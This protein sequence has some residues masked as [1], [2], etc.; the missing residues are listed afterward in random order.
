M[1]L[2]IFAGG[3]GRRLWPISRQKSPKQ[4]EPILGDKSTL[5]LAVDRVLA[6]YGGENIFISTNEKYVEMVRAQLPQ[7][8]AENVIGEPAR[9]DLA[10][11][12]GLALTHLAYRAKDPEEPVAILWGDNYMDQVP[13]F[14]GVLAAAEELLHTEQARIL[15]VGETPRFA[16]DNLGW[17]GLGE[18][19]GEV[20]GR[21]YYRFA[22]LTYRPPLA[23]C[24]RMFAEKTH[25]W[26]TGYFV[27]T[28]GFVR[29]QYEQRQPEI[30]QQL[31]EIGQTIG[32]ADYLATLHRVYPQI[33]SMSFDDAILQHIAPQ[34]AAVLHGH[35]GWSDP[36]TLYAL[37]EAINPNLAANVT[38]GQV[39]VHQSSDCLIY[40]YETD[41]LV[42]VVGLDGMIVV[43]MD[44][45]LL[46]VHKDQ[47]PLVK[48]MVNG[49]E[50]GEFEKYS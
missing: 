49:L 37:K 25:V 13:T 1:K 5:Q 34:D 12:V 40:N 38:K 6:T 44:D 22:S 29:Q 18:A 41:K 4:F 23:D 20:N 16:N 7:I 35:M 39:I 26:N 42:T 43:N 14:L 46:V 19:L 3:S 15:F 48:Q 21:S 36:G 24:Q 50:G 32:Q 30:W 10:A 45:T 11:A 17:I 8:P 9:R 2:I 27:T 33:A 47:I 31:A 28:I